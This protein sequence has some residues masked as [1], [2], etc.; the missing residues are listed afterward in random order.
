MDDEFLW[1]RNGRVVDP[2]HGVDGV[3]DLLLAG[4]LIRAVGRD[5]DPPQKARMLDATGLVVAPGLVDMHVH[6]RE[7]GFE[8]KETIAGGCQAA[9]AGGVTSLAAMPN[10]RP[11]MD[12]IS[13][14]EMVLERAR[15]AG[16]ANVY[17]IGAI[18]KGM[19]GQELTE[20]GRLL[21]AGCVAFSDDGKGS[22]GSGVMRRALQYA[23]TFGALLIQHAEDPELSRDGL[24]HEG[25]VS[26][27]LGLTGIPSAAEEVVVER[28]VRLVGLTGGRYH[29]AHLSTAGAVATVGRAREQGLPVTAEVTPH[30]L[31]LLDEDVGNYDPLRK[32]SP[33]LRGRADR[34]ALREGLARGVITAIATDHAPHDRD[35]KQVEFGRASLG[36]VGLETLLPVALSLV[37]EGVLSLSRVLALMTC[38]PAAILGIN[39]GSLGVGK[40]A[41]VV[42]FDPDQEWM[43][44][45]AALHGTS[46]N[47]C[48]L[49][50]TMRGRVR[51]TV[52]GGR[53]VYR[54][55]TDG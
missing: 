16:L 13:V 11:V 51:Y 26:G 5:V 27:R 53:L 17:P 4:G 2:A 54:D 23:S 20:M 19:G 7:P 44:T 12:E 28:D 6:L 33:P 22:V 46:R 31:T 41:D 36:V 49:G 38:Q 39:R 43:V 45:E 40:A 21:R 32:M 35:S 15:L 50:H 1:I 18:T 30:H 25:V 8:Y 48:Y 42:V 37:R 47:S 9:V 14:V 10:T 3:G 55:G 24:M 52:V 29:V 34:A